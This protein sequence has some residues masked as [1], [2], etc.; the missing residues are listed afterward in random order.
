VVGDSGNFLEEVYELVPRL[1]KIL[2]TG[3]LCLASLKI[4][5]ADEPWVPAGCLQSVAQHTLEKLEYCS[6]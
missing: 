1:R 5:V 2:A 4:V 3:A 6:F